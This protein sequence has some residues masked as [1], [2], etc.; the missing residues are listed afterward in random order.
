M[1]LPGRALSWL[2]SRSTSDLAAIPDGRFAI[3]DAR[4]HVAQPPKPEPRVMRSK[5]I[6][7]SSE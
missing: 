2:G 1:V 7:T 3:G 5:G 6:V 4:E